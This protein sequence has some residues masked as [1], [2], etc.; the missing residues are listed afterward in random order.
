MSHYIVFFHFFVAYRRSDKTSYISKNLKSVH[1][2]NTDVKHVNSVLDSTLLV[3]MHFCTR[4]PCYQGIPAFF[5]I[6]T[7]DETWIIVH[8]D[9]TLYHPYQIQHEISR[10]VQG[11]R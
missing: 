3:I 1:Y 7:I 2:G 8:S 9:S 4:F 11:L 5:K 10:D 6:L